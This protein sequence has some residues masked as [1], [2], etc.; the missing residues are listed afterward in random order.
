M[1]SQWKNVNQISHGW[2]AAFNLLLGIFALSCIV[3]V[4]LVFMI[5]IS[6]VMS[7]A[8]KGYTFFPSGINFQAYKFL[9]TDRETI[10]N[11]YYVSILQTVVG[12]VLSVILTA[13]MAYPLSRSCFRYKNAVTFYIFFTMLFSG[14]LIPWYMICANVLRLRNTFWA[15]V[16]PYLM[17]PFNVIIMRTFFKTTIHDSLIESAKLDGASELRVLLWIVLPL[18]LP[19]LATIGLFRAIAYWNDWWLP[20]ILVDNNKWINLQ[21]AMTQ[22][23]RSATYLADLAASGATGSTQTELARMPTESVRMAMCIVSMG[24]IVLAYPFCQKYF[25]KGLTI[26]AVKG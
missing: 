4:V 9:M 5:S 25:V 6:D 22:V 14:G 12:T 7:I 19:V 20:T 24:P 18:S 16:V 26:G 1:K 3:P 15:L 11:V 21:Y 10:F 23:I 13:L 8:T 2:N 17:A